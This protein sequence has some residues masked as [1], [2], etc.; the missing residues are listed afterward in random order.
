MTLTLS[1]P[2]FKRLPTVKNFAIAPG[3]KFTG[4]ISGSYPGTYMKVTIYDMHNTIMHL[5]VSM[6][7]HNGVGDHVWAGNCNVEDFQILDLH[8]TE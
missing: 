8:T 6:T 2:K 4:S 5:I 1:T 3:V 7:E